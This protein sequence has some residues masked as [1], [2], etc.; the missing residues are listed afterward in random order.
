MHGSKCVTQS[1]IS[2]PE[3]AV[4]A[5]RLGVVDAAPE[6]VVERVLVP[7]LVVGLQHL[8]PLLGGILKG[9]AFTNWSACSVEA[10][11]H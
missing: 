11:G 10:E 4:R 7:H 5:A 8:I 3:G 2:P 6:Q 1:V 9:S